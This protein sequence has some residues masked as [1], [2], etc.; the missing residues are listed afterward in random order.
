[1]FGDDNQMDDDSIL[2]VNF[3]ESIV[4]HNENYKYEEDK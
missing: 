4:I 2:K 1:M 3:N